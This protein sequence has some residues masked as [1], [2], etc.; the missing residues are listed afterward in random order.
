MI[1]EGNDTRCN[2]HVSD[3]PS[4]SLVNIVKLMMDKEYPKRNYYSLRRN[5]FHIFVTIYVFPEFI[6]I[7]HKEVDTEETNN[8]I[9]V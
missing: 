6:T 8:I 5:L 3:T 2:R 9:H 7:K 4:L 1:A